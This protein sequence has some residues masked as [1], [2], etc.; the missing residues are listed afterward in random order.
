MP[1]DGQLKKDDYILVDS[2]VFPIFR[3]YSHFFPLI[4]NF[5]SYGRL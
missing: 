1:S 3:P 2:D 5:R 4:L